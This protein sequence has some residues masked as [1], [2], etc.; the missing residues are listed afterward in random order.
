MVD[1]RRKWSL[2]KRACFLRVY[3]QGSA[4][5]DRYLVVKSVINDLGFTRYGFSV[6]K[7]IGNAVV[8]NRTRRVL[9]EIVR[10]IQ[11]KPGWDIVFIARQDINNADFNVLHSSIMKLL[12][13]ADLLLYKDETV[14]T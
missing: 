6:T 7:S 9:K 2:K 11:I 8:R 12:D 5:A 10:V 4:K 13:R 14:S 1:M 3:E